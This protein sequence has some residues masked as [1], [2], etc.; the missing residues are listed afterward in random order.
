M[1]FWSHTWT[2]SLSIKNLNVCWTFLKKNRSNFLRIYYTY[3]T[4][5]QHHRIF[6]LFIHLVQHALIFH[7][8]NQSSPSVAAASFL[9]LHVNKYLNS[10]RQYNWRRWPDRHL[11]TYTYM[12]Y[13]NSNSG[14]SNF[15]HGEGNFRSLD[16]DDPRWPDAGPLWNRQRGGQRSHRVA[17]VVV[18]QPLAPV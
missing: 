10:I 14:V 15:G 3:N 16:D 12:Q 13:S 5:S 9:Y 4:I 17:T 1:L 2:F 18:L 11:K 7:F 6:I 8:P